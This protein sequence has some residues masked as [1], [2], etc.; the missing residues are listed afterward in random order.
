MQPYNKH[1]LSDSQADHLDIKHILIVSIF[2]VRRIQNKYRQH[3]N[4]LHS[5]PSAETITSDDSS[6]PNGPPCSPTPYVIMTSARLVRRREPP[7]RIVME[8]RLERASH[9][10][11]RSRRGFGSADESDRRSASDRKAMTSAQA[12]QDAHREFVRDRFGRTDDLPAGE[13]LFAHRSDQ[14]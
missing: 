4:L 10:V 8:E 12:F 3:R 13:R 7:A 5:F 6:T 14:R 1:R 11:A 2:H 9:E